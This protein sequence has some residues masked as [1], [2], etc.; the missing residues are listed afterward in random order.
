MILAKKNPAIP[1]SCAK[2]HGVILIYF[3]FSGDHTCLFV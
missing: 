1:T 3:S 2:S